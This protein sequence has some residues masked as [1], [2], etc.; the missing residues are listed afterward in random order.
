MCPCC[1]GAEHLACSAAICAGSGQFGTAAGALSSERGCRLHNRWL[2]DFCAKEPHRRIGVA[3]VPVVHD[4]D[5]AVAEI[6]EVHDRGLR[7]RAD[8][9]SLDDRACVPRSP[10]RAGVVDDRGASAWC[11]TR[12]PGRTDRLRDRPRI[13]GDLRDRGLLVGRSSA[14]GPVWPACSNGT[15]TAVCDHRERCLVAAGHRGE[16]GREV[17][18]RPQHQE[19]RQCVPREPQ[20]EAE[21]LHRSQLLPR[22]VDTGVDDIGRRYEIGV[23]N[24][25]WG[26]DFPHPE[27]TFPY[28]RELVRQ[29]FKD[30][31]EDET[32]RIL[33][34]NAVDLY[35]IDT[36]TLAALVERI[37]PLVAEIH[38]D[39]PL[40]TVVE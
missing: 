24:L 26:N 7:G 20:H 22:R 36:A 11:C 3:I 12:T 16:D 25:L 32:R 2:A 27:G 6:E 23:G 8:P 21:R 17:H 33:G 19:A 31:P 4:I 14:L 39:T 18:R 30:V 40:A 1:N 15:R 13:H 5:A 29:R 28:T 37:G 35:G 34:L 9:D 10:L 38:G